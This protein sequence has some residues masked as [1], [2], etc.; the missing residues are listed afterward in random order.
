M[1]PGGNVQMWETS[2]KCAGP[3]TWMSYVKT[4]E[5]GTWHMVLGRWESWMCQVGRLGRLDLA[6]WNSN[7]TRH[8]CVY[9]NMEILTSGGPPITNPHG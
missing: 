2:V 6:G 1:M 5:L 3:G 4:D 9:F 8:E 7:Q